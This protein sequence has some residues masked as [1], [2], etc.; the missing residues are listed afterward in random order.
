MLVWGS[1]GV[2]RDLG[3]VETQRCDTC[4]T[5][6][7]FRLRLD[8][9]YGH[10]WYVFKWVKEKQYALT[11]EGCH[12]GRILEA[13]KIEQTLKEPPIPF[14]T[15]Y[16]WAFAVALVAVA[17]TLGPLQARAKKQEDFT[18]LAAPQ[19]GDL[20]VADL[21]ELMKQ[22]VARHMWGVL[23][24][25]AVSGDAV[26]LEV[27]EG[28]YDR[29]TGARNDVSAGKARAAD[30]FDHQRSLSIPIAD[31]KQMR[32]RGAIDEVVRP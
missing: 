15:R 26:D 32:E 28:Y 16:G 19:A 5:L 30:Y 9:R 7:S 17:V 29:P 20:Y 8:Y 27:S 2:T 4:Q 11:C 24:A 31:L 18:F 13:R 10:V 21:A 12:N 3:I 1:G 25:T 6:R 22:P 14:F 23:R